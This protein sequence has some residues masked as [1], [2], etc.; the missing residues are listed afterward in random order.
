VDER[1]VWVVVVAGHAY[2]RAAFGR[3]SRWYRQLEQRP[4]VRIGLPDRT[5][6]PAR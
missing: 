4:E 3:D 6:S 1:V 2:V 5:R